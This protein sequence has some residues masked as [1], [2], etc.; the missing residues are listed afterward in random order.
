MG[1]LESGLYDL[2]TITHLTQP[3]I[4]GGDYDG[5]GVADIFDGELSN[6]IIQ[7][8]VVQI[9]KPPV[10]QDDTYQDFRLVKSDDSI[11]G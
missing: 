1:T 2:H 8:N 6:K 7:I 9:P 5:D 11:S 10:V 3:I 4:D